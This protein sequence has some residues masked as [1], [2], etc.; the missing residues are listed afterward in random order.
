MFQL[1]KSEIEQL[2]TLVEFEIQALKNLEIPPI[3]AAFL[4]KETGVLVEEEKVAG[5]LRAYVIEKIQQLQQPKLDEVFYDFAIHQLKQDHPVALP[6]DFL[7][8]QLLSNPELT[9]EMVEKEFPA[10]LKQI[11]TNVL[12]RFLVKQGNLTLRA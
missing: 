3:N 9:P 7:K 4:E 6:E 12:E 8:A 10:F 1:T 5:Q 2:P 11:R